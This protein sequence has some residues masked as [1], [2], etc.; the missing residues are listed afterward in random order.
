MGFKVGRFEWPTTGHADVMLSAVMARHGIG[1][2]TLMVEEMQAADRLS[3]TTTD[4][5]ITFD[6]GV[7][8][9]ALRTPPRKATRLEGF[10]IGVM[11]LAILF[12]VLGVGSALV[13][14]AWQWAL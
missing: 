1:K 3:I 2:V 14:A 7:P 10:A 9:S 13:W 6:R 4:N 11:F 5:T 12:V 8:N